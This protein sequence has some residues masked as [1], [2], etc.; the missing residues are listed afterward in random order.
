VYLRLANAGE[1]HVENRAH[2][3]AVA[4]RAS[5]QI[6]SNYARLAQTAKRGSGAVIASLAHDAGSAHDVADV[7]LAAADRIEALDEALQHL[8]RLHPRPCRVV[9]CRFFGGL[10]IAETAAA[11]HL[12]EATVKRDWAVAQAWLHRA[13]RDE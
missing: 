5:R 6:V 13:L 8:E 9:E 2:F 12:S 10:S 4:V 11:L 7:S 1:L 3:F